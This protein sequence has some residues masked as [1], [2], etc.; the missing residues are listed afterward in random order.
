MLTALDRQAVQ[1][2]RSIE[3]GVNADTESS[4][5]EISQADLDIA[6]VHPLGQN[7][8]N[9]AD[10]KTVFGAVFDVDKRTEVP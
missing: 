3:R 1:V 5:I 10:P 8:T 4:I 9:V 2:A 6:R 7:I